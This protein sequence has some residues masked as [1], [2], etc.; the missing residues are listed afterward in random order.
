MLTQ[1]PDSSPAVLTHHSMPVSWDQSLEL[2]H[3]LINSVELGQ[4]EFNKQPPTQTLPLLLLHGL[5]I[6]RQLYGMK[7]QAH[8]GHW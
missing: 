1:H 3:I 5:L 6:H 4:Q 7:L 2:G 8:R